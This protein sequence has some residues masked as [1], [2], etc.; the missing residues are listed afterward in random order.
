VL[1]ERVD[2]SQQAGV[3]ATLAGIVMISAG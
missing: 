2:R 3:L 1:H